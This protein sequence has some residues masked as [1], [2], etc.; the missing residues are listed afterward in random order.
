MLMMMFETL[1]LHRMMTVVDVMKT[2]KILIVWMI[3]VMLDCLTTVAIS[4]L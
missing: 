4:V 2:L 1:M 3:K